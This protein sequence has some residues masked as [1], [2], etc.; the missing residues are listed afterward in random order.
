[1]RKSFF[2]IVGIAIVVT[3]GIYALQ[4]KPPFCANSVS[5]VKDL[6]GAYDPTAKQAVF[7]GKAFSVPSEIAHTEF[8][9]PVLGEH[10]GEEKHIY[11]D[12]SHQILTA[13][14]GGQLIYSFP[15]STGKWHHTPTGEFNIW[16]KLK[17]T[18]MVGGD[19]RQGTYYN[20]PNV[21]YT[22]FFYNEDV[23]KGEG[24]GI[25][26]AYW[27]NNFGQP[28]SHGC[29]NM[30]T[31]DVEKLFYWADPPTTGWSSKTN[32]ASEGTRITIYGQTPSPDTTL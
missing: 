12:L 22:M 11:I 17:Y 13:F 3:A 1:M 21:P 4:P 5:C 30:K 6:S 14:E 15:V 28:M 19:P 10:T 31:E 20:L 7:L 9:S 8:Q 32:D 18:R 23:P 2:V 29:V 24:Y 27:H 25:H 26:G 16:V